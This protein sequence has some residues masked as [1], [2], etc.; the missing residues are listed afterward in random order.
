MVMKVNR[1]CMSIHGFKNGTVP[2]PR[3]KDA[4][5]NGVTPVNLRWGTYGEKVRLRSGGMLVFQDEQVFP[6]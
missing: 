3:E 1:D 4:R 6:E 5:L 2:Y